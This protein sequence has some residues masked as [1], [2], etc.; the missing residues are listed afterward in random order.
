M[1]WGRQVW[2]TTA[3]ADGKRMSV[4]CVDRDSGRVVRE[5][6]LF[7]NA[8]P[9]SRNPLNSYASPTPC[10]EAGRLYVNF[11]TYGTA[12]LDTATGKTLW[13]RRDLKCDHGVGPGSSPLL[14]GG[15]LFLLFDGMDVQFV[16][17]LDKATGRTVWKTPR[18]V[19][20]GSTDGD[21]RKA[22]STPLLV[23]VA[24]RDQL[25]CAGAGAAI[26][27]DPQTGKE[28]WRVRYPGGFST[29]A[30]P[31]AGPDGL[32]YVHSGFSRHH[33]LAVRTTGRGDVTE[34]HVA[35]QLKRG[36]PAKPSSVYAGGLLYVLNDGGTLS[37][38]DGRTGEKV[39]RERLGGSYSA[40]PLAAPGR[41]YLFNTRGTTKV[42]RPG[43]EFQLLATNK[44]DDGCMASAAV[45][46]RS[47]YVRTKT[48]LYRIE[49][50]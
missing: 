32:V 30:R 7:E 42:V 12:C 13:S 41:I 44:L 33:M 35:W 49:K 43:R 24:G 14:S 8:R 4:L 36:G 46:G 6:V 3:T 1:V 18:G 25:V 22:F 15:R 34:T 31:V 9:A 23:R 20:F 19:D 47:L 10:I 40:S 2:L 39:W 5:K 11:G 28:I 21:F 29:A 17:A 50:R 45:A 38:L 37:C 27:Y 26:A 48:H 16:V